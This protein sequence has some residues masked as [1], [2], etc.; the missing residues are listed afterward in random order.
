MRVNLLY[1][2]VNEAEAKLTPR[3]K[4]GLTRRVYGL[5]GKYK[6]KG[7]MKVFLVGKK[8]EEEL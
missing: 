2:P 6:G 7:M 3:Q 8:R 5:L 4:K 1:E